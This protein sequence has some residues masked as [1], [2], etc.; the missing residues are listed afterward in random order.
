M[1]I[2]DKTEII[3]YLENN[4][5]THLAKISVGCYDEETCQVVKVR[6]LM[7]AIEKV[8]DHLCI[9]DNDLSVE[10]AHQIERTNDLNNKLKRM[11]ETIDV[12]NYICKHAKIEEALHD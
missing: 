8:T 11:C 1:T 5:K 3:A 9:D 2:N 4:L 7:S 10:L 12:I 6:D